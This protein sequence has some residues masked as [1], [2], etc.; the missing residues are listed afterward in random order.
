MGGFECATHINTAGRRLD[1]IAG[2]QHDSQAEHD[3]ALL[4]S[5]GMQA[6]RDGLR[7]HR[8]DRGSQGYDW[9]SFE[10]MF[11][12][13]ARQGVQVIWD[14]CHYGWP[15]GL[16]VLSPAFV[17]RYVRFARAVAQF[18]RNKSDEVPFYAPMNEI[19][20]LCWGAARDL[21]YPFAFGR[22]N[23]IKHN[24]IRATVAGCAAI[25]D[26]DPRARFVY[27]EPIVKVLPPRHRP[28]LAA[29]ARQHHESQFEAWNMIAG[30]QE[31][32][33]GGDPRFL[34]ILGAN[35]Y[36]SNEWEI[37]GNGRLRWEDEPR[38]DRWVPLHKLLTDIYRRYRRPL[39][40]AE[41]SHFGSGRARWILEVA[42]EV[43]KA[44][45]EGT[46][47]DGI[48]LY[49]V[50]DRYDWQDAN[51]WHNSGLWDFQ[52]ASDGKL[53]RTLNQTYASALTKSRQL[54]ASIGCV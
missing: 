15:D 39:F 27:P 37:E 17:D 18:V 42:D 43:L 38:D 46:P 12:A 7:W 53:V 30:Y 47:I 26:V 41:T 35:F 32:S 36:H 51:H 16:D 48:C 54:L 45:R 1:M 8:I 10:P 49:P 28:D 6:T 9:S 24:L 5:Q 34:D 13:A 23:D 19:N 3:Y 31:P 4:K 14:I 29:Q 50:I 22:D 21:I 40:V 52:H 44:R 25:L 20:F 2:V 33:L 11:D